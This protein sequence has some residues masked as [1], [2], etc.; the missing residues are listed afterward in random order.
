MCCCILATTSLLYSRDKPPKGI[1]VAS[2]AKIERSG[3]Q[4]EEV[5]TVRIAAKHGTPPY[6]FTIVRQEFTIG[7]TELWL[8]ARDQAGQ[9]KIIKVILSN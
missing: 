5:F 1:S 2:H 3:P 9:K 8:E 6:T 7:K 4:A